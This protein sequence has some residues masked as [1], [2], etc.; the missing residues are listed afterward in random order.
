MFRDNDRHRFPGNMI[1]EVWRGLKPQWNDFPYKYPSSPVQLVALRGL[2][3]FICQRSTEAT[4]I[5]LWGGVETSGF[6]RCHLH[7]DQ[8]QDALDRPV[9][10]KIATS[11][12]MLAYSQLL[13]RPPSR[14]M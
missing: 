11:L 14:H 5:V 12:E 10:E 3:R 7:E 9:V 2:I 13:H 4:V 1:F 6:K 8:A